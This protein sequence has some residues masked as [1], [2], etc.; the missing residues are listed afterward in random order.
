MERPQ[1][2]MHLTSYGLG[3]DDHFYK[4]WTNAKRR[5]D[6]MI[7]QALMNNL[8]GNNPGELERWADDGGYQP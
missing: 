4:L 3:A 5:D 8:W 7:Y 6:A 2:F 1:L